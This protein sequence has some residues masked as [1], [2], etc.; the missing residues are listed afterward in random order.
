MEL[1]LKPVDKM[2]SAR[3]RRGENQAAAEKIIAALEE[4]NGGPLLAARGSRHKM[5]SVKNLLIKAGAEA[6][7][8][9]TDDAEVFELT[10]AKAPF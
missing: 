2:P 8:S 7:V 6:V 1:V 10:A 9:A 3:G 4:A 5:D